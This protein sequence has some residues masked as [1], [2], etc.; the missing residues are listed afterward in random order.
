MISYCRS[1]IIREVVEKDRLPNELLRLETRGKTHADLLCEGAVRGRDIEAFNSLSEWIE[2]L[3]WSM[4][5]L[6]EKD[7]LTAA[8]HALN[9]TPKLA[10]TDYMTSRQRDLGQLWTDTIRGFLGEIALAKWLKEKFNVDVELDYRRGPLSEFL[11]SDIKS[12]NRRKPR[13]N[14]SIKTTKFRGIWL[15]VPGKQIEHSDI[16]IL[17]RVGVSRE[18]FIAFL[19]KISI[20]RDKLLKLARELRVADEEELRTIWETVPEFQPIPAYIAGFLDKHDFIDKLDKEKVII[21]DGRLTGRKK[22]RLIIDKYLGLWDP[23]EDKMTEKVL[24]LLKRKY[25]NIPSNIDIEFEGIGSFTKGL[26]FIA[27]S[28][29]LKRRENEWRALLKKL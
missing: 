7:Y 24:S 8:I 26:H 3:R 18:H 9:L 23:R 28:G 10:G 17:S 12:V 27:S 11:P 1:Y 5:I 25:P 2:W 21:V 4:V 16:F 6:D 13:L 14:I 15:D 22:Y 20:I 19:K 29:V